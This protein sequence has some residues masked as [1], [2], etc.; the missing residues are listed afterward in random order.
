[1]KVKGLQFQTP[2]RLSRDTLKVPDVGPDYKGH[3]IQVDVDARIAM[4]T[5]P[6]GSLAIP[7]ENVA[8]FDLEIEPVSKPT[9]ADVDR[10]AQARRSHTHLM[11]LRYERQPKLEHPAGPLAGPRDTDPPEPP[12]IDEQAQAAPPHDQ[13]AE[14]PHKKTKR[15]K[16]AK[17]A[18]K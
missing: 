17:K 4:V 2:V 16:R 8:A 10:W 12:V 7:F 11:R 13:P 15:R 1:M 14:E 18:K 9:T 5:T 6:Q 3:E